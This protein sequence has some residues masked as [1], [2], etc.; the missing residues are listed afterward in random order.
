MV[1]LKIL[2]IAVAFCVVALG[3]GMI[4]GRLF[5]V[6]ALSTNSATAQPIQA[7]KSP[8]PTGVAG[9]SQAT[10][11]APTQLPASSTGTPASPANTPA[12]TLAAPSATAVPTPTLEIAYIEYTVQKGDILY[13]LAERY[14]VTIEDI[15]AINEIPNPKSLSVGQVIRIPKK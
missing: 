8:E 3:A 14:N 11:V 2:G 13:T 4:V 15:L 9:V 7:R 6:G 10:I 12:P 1:R 5:S